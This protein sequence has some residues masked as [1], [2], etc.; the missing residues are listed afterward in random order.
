MVTMQDAISRSAKFLARMR[1]VTKDDH[2]DLVVL[3]A[4]E[5][6]NDYTL[7]VEFTANLVLTSRSR[8]KI[9]IDKATGTVTG[10][11]KKEQ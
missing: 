1:G 9:T 7:D 8:F 3:D 10:I 5:V 2:V 6:G 11:E 4:R